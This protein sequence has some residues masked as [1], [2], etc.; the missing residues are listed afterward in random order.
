LMWIVLAVVLLLLSTCLFYRAFMNTHDVAVNRITIE[1][2]QL[3][4]LE[5]KD[6]RS[7]HVLQLSDLHLEHLSVSP[8]RL[9]RMLAQERIDLI[10][11][12]GDFMD[13]KRSIP[14]IV[15]YLDALNRLNA[16]YGMYAVFGNHDYWLR[17]E[18][19]RKLKDVLNKHGCRTLQN[20][21][22]KLSVGGAA[23]NLIGIDDFGSGR[24]DLAASYRGVVSPGYNL[25]LTHDPN[26]VLEMRD[27][28]YDYL[29]SGHF[30]GGQICWPKPYHLVKMGKMARMNVIKGLHHYD[31]KPFYINEGLGQTGVNIRIGS[32]PEITLHQI[33]FSDNN[34]RLR[35]GSAS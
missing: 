9:L 27:Y 7:L 16:T 29:L 19:F 8:E 15:P 12:T 13:R 3:D 22:V 6:L 23:V 20:D 28:E 14:K 30:H 32:R 11:I 24:S 26:I 4:R 33:I 10:A 21:H 34:Y 1:Q 17:E 31:G 5:E 2:P 25:V 35:L 18:P